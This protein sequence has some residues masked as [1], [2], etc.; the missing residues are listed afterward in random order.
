MAR[1]LRAAIFIAFIF[2]GKNAF[3]ACHVV[4]PSGSGSKT[5]ADWNNAYAGLP[6]TLTRGDIYYLADGSYSDYTFSTA[7]SGTTTVG[8]RK[9]QSYDN[10][11]STGWNT[12]T[13]GSGQAKFNSLT[14]S[15]T[16][17][18]DVNGNGISTAQ[19][20]GVSPATNTSASDC[21]IYFG[22]GSGGNTWPVLLGP[23]GGGNNSNMTFEYVEVEGANQ[24]IL[25][26]D[27]W[28]CWTTCSNIVLNHIYSF[29]SGCVFFKIQGTNAFTVEN[30]YIW[31]N[32][33]T[34][35]C[36]GQMWLTQGNTSNVDFHNNIIRDITGTGVFVSVTGG[37]L[38]NWNV[39]NNV[40]WHTQGNGTF[41]YSN[42]I[43][44]AV[45]SG[46]QATNFKF[47]GNSVV[48]ATQGY[49]TGA[50]LENGGGSLTFQNN[51]WYASDAMNCCG[52]GNPTVTEDHNSCINM[53][54]GSFSAGTDV[55]V[56][57]GA[58]NPFVNWSGGNFNIATENAD[59]TN[60]LPLGLPYNV[61]PNGTIRTT[62]RGAYQYSVSQTQA[63]KPPTGLVAT[64]Q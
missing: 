12:S 16:G 38:T 4:T 50:N 32:F 31:K 20:C 23:S 40:F 54:C 26:E 3:A 52:N 9:A 47:I 55:K 57:S 11:T 17:Y 22:P 27:D 19:G 24:S 48:S 42:G 30:S 56:S 1:L 10:C 49:T 61:D 39:Y 46:S 6:G 51:T 60:W 63:P 5:G 29:N 13:M 41:G 18:L 25:E 45:N 58:P 37:Q 62:D 2:S 8:I 43:I 36:H 28:M 14:I 64:V 44:A 15:N 7:I 59:W 21:G 53:S 33:D 34:S 35:S